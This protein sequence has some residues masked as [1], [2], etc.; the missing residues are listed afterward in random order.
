MKARSRLD[1]SQPVRTITMK[2]RVSSLL[3]SMPL[4][5]TSCS[6]SYPITVE[7][8]AKYESSA[9][10]SDSWL[11]DHREEVI[12]R[13]VEYVRKQHPSTASWFPRVALGTVRLEISKSKWIRNELIEKELLEIFRG[14]SE[15]L[16]PPSNNRTAW[17]LDVDVK[18][19]RPE[20]NPALYAVAVPYGILCWSNLLIA[21]PMKMSEYVV[22]DTK[23][24][25]AKDERFEIRAIGGS[26]ILMSSPWVQDNDAPL[27]EST[28]KALAAAVADFANK[29]VLEVEKRLVRPP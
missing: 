18:F 27:Y 13:T 28:S 24:T 9:P 11:R 6:H 10:I 3:I 21:C 1:Y 29:L 19:A 7:E 8:S 12:K 4:A 26:T 17:T 20:T 23:L 5:L 2:T 22:L 16:L 15:R 14:T 25:T